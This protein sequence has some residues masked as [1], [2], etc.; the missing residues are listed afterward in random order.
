MIVRKGDRP[1]YTSEVEEGAPRL[2][3]LGQVAGAE[4]VDPSLLSPPLPALPTSEPGRQSRVIIREQ[5]IVFERCV[6][7]SQEEG[8]LSDNNGQ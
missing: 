1:P 8:L 4:R 7:T 5:I 6:R 3:T 2:V